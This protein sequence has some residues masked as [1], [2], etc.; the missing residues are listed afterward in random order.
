MREER[1]SNNNQDLYNIKSNQSRD[2]N[3][4]GNLLFK[5]K[6]KKKKKVTKCMQSNASA[7]TLAYT[8]LF[9]I[10]SI[11]IKCTNGIKHNLLY[12]IFFE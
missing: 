11:N 10:K 4:G 12:F 7:F 6:E 1:G 3:Y 5:K 9:P 2:T 8:H